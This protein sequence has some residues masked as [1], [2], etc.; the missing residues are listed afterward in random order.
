MKMINVPELIQTYIWD[1]GPKALQSVFAYYGIHA[2]EEDIIKIAGTTRNGTPISGM[3]KAVKKY[4]L[5]SAAGKMTIE[6]VKSYINRGIPVILLL[7]AWP[8]KKIKDWSRHW[9][10]GHYVVVVR[11]TARRIIFEDPWVL[12][13]SYLTYEELAERWHDRI[14]GRRYYSFGM[15]VYGENGSRRLK[16]IVHMG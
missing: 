9:D 14:G 12:S 13:R 7:Q 1:C 4:G 5:K 15:A 11:Y 6:E 10:D 3:K 8:K 2:R 16:R